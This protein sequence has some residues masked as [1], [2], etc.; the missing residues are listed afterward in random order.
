VSNNSVKVQPSATGTNMQTFENTVS[1]VVVDSEAVTLVRSSDNTEVGVSAQ[2]LRIDPVGTTAQPVTQSAP[3][4]SVT[5]SP[6][7]TGGT[8]DY[9]AVAAGSTNLGVVKA[10]AGQ[11]F[12]WNIFNNAAYPIYV[13]LFNKASNPLLGTD[14]PVRTIGVQAGTQFSYFNAIGMAFATGIALAITKLIADADTTAILAND[15]VV[16]LDFK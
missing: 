1:A 5:V 16:D 11:L 7:T 9:H 2:P 6:A 15:C 8:S 12:G 3:P 14:V 13:K 4:W 10:S